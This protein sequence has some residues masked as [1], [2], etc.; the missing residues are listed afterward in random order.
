MLSFDSYRDVLREHARGHHFVGSAWFVVVAII[1][2]LV[3]FD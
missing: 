3:V 1:V 2:F